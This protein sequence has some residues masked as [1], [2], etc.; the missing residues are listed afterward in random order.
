M[1][2]ILEGE[3]FSLFRCRKVLSNMPSSLAKTKLIGSPMNNGLFIFDASLLLTISQMIEKRVQVV[4]SSDLRPSLRKPPTS[5]PNFLK[6]KKGGRENLIAEEN[7]QV[8]GR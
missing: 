5:R 3:V 1:L 4:F 8:V 6:R 7:S 2:Y